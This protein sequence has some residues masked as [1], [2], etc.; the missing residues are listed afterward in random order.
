MGDIYCLYLC[1]SK[2]GAL[3][4]VKAIF[5]KKGSQEVTEKHSLLPKTRGKAEKGNRV[6]VKVI[7][8]K[9]KSKR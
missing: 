3:L 7:H 5:V 2:L 4:I 1:L 8:P 9:K 6:E